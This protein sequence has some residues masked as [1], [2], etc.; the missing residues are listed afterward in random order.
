MKK[1]IISI[2]FLV[3][4]SNVFSQTIENELVINEKIKITSINLRI[5]HSAV[6]VKDVVDEN[7]KVQI[8]KVPTSVTL[9]RINDK[10]SNYFFHYNYLEH[11]TI[12]VT[13]ENR[14]KFE[15]KL[16]DKLVEKMNTI[17]IQKI[18]KSDGFTFDGSSYYLSFSNE[19]Y[20]ISIFVDNP[21]TDSKTRNLVEFLE[22]CET[23]S[24][25]TSYD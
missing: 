24:K 7:G 17:N 22:I 8:A 21:K 6:Y 3:L 18:K 12:Y 10:E 9:D 20:K 5:H 14:I 25:L 16:F 23:I 15:T 1:I 2:F 4:Y 19:N 11:D 13:L